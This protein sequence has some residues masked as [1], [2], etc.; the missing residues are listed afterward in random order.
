M[1]NRILMDIT[2]ED[3]LTE[4]HANTI[5]KTLQNHSTYSWST[6]LPVFLLNRCW[7]KLEKISI[8]ELSGR[9]PPDNSEEAPELVFYQNL[10]KNGHNPILALHE[11]WDQFGIE[12]FHR[13]LRIYWARREAGNNGWT[14]KKYIKLITTYRRN[15]KDS[16]ISAPVLVLARDSKGEGHRITWFK[17]LNR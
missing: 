15:I 17:L 8:A 6:Q 14:F 11:S 3:Y 10:I 12:E 9:L 5:R 2:I 1:H 7:L 13:A 16:I 4:R